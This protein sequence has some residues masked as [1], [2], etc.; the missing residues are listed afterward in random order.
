M[1]LRARTAEGHCE[2]MRYCVRVGRAI[3]AITDTIVLGS[4]LAGARRAVREPIHS[5]GTGDMGRKHDGYFARVSSDHEMSCD[6]D[7]GDVL[8][9]VLFFLMMRPPPKSTLFPYTTL[10]R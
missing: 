2:I 10:F 3:E 9:C 7:T 5:S 1:F 4:L 6:F 8:Y